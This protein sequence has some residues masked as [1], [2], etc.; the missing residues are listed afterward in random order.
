MIGFMGN[1]LGGKIGK[2]IV[3]V[4]GTTENKQ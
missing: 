1:Y 4:L 2:K 3:E